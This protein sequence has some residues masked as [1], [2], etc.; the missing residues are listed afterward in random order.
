MTKQ[1]ENVKDLTRVTV[2]NNMICVKKKSQTD[3]R[4]LTSEIG[5]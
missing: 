1:Y 5:R 4:Q 2:S 3:N